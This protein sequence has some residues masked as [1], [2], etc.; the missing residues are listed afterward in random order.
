MLRGE[1]APP[2]AKS[3][4]VD[5]QATAPVYFGALRRSG[6]P[7]GAGSAPHAWIHADSTPRGRAVPRGRGAPS[8]L[9]RPGSPCAHF[10][11]VAL[12]QR[13]P[14]AR[15]ARRYAVV[16]TPHFARRFAAFIRAMGPGRIL[17]TGPMRCADGVPDLPVS[18]SAFDC[19]TIRIGSCESGATSVVL[20]SLLPSPFDDRAD[21]FERATPRGR[22]K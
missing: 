22:I 20:R 5:R 4:P 2:R 14:A 13:R 11:L 16:L 21:E 15:Q 6:V 8:A 10:T 9:H 12:A 17:T 1:G 3:V 19:I 7:A 18:P